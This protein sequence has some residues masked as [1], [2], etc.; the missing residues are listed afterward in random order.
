MS[1][2]GSGRPRT[3]YSSEQR[4]LALKRQTY[5]EHAIG[6]SHEPGT[7]CTTMFDS[8]TPDARSFAFV[9]ARRG[10]IIAKILVPGGV[11]VG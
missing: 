11:V 8:L 4:S 5:L 9:P 6:S 1:W 3:V 10:S 2:T 7:D